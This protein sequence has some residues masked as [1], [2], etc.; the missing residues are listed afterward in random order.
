MIAKTA[1]RTPSTT[2]VIAN[3]TWD[4][5]V[6]RGQPRDD[7]RDQDDREDAHQDPQEVVPGADAS[8]PRS[9]RAEVELDLLPVEEAVDEEEHAPMNMICVP[10]PRAFNL[11]M[12]PVLSSSPAAVVTALLSD[13]R[14]D[15]QANRALS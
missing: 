13:L 3:E 8:A 9:E 14:A 1:M 15:L 11:S 10:R 4:R 2:L 6:D 12:R 7:P 5:D